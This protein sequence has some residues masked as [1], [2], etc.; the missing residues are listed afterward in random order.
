[1]HSFVTSKNAQWPRLIWPTL[2]TRSCYCDLKLSIILRYRTDSL[3]QHTRLSCTGL[4]QRPFKCWHYT[5]Y[6]DFHGP[7]A[8][9]WR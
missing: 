4:P 2:Y 6:A 9:S 3:P 1:M 5:K 8:K 7:D